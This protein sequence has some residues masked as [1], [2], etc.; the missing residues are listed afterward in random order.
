[1]FQLKLED[2]KNNPD[3]QL[4]EMGGIQTEHAER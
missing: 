2:W 4:L 3:R 1:M